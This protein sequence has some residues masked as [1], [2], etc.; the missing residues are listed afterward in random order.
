LRDAFAAARLRASIDDADWDRRR[1]TK[2]GILHGLAAE[3]SNGWRREGERILDLGCGAASYPAHRRTGAEV[4]GVDAS[5]E[6][7]AAARG[8]G[9]A[10]AKPGRS[11]AY[12]DASFD[13]VFSNA[14][15]HW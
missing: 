6:M 9:I 12:A 8:R 10:P 15:L 4:E 3:C 2:W 14:A 5:P 7:V 13:A 1:T 11:L